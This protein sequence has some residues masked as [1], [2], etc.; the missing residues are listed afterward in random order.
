MH[1]PPSESGPPPIRVAVDMSN[2]RPAGENGGVKPFLFETLRWLGRQQRVPLQL[3]YLTCA[4]THAEV[5]DELARIDDEV[6]C[7]RDDG[8]PLPRGDERAPRERR[9]IP[10]PRDLLRQLGAHV[11]YSPFGPV[12][13]AAPGICTISTIVDVLH[14]DFPWSL[15]AQE[16]ASRESAFEEIVAVADR[17]QCISHHV[18]ARMQAHYDVPDERMFTVHIAVHGRF[19]VLAAASHASPEA[20]AEAPPVP[21][22]SAPF[23]FYPANTWK[24]KNHETLLLAYGIYRA[25][26]VAAGQ[27]PWPLVLTGHVD[28]RWEEL[29]TLAQTLGLLGHD[30]V[31][32]EGYVPAHQFGRLW[33]AAG[34]LV[35][36]SLHEGFGIPLLEAMQHDLPVL[37]SREGSLPEVG[38]DACLYVDARSPVALA[39]AM[40][41]LA[42]DPALR[43]RLVEA[44]RRRLDDFSL[45]RESGRL[46]DAIVELSQTTPPYRAQTSG[47]HLD[48]W[49]EPI[50]SLALPN[51]PMLGR[52]TLRFHAMPVHRRVRLRASDSVAFGSFD[53]PTFQ[54]G[55][56][57]SVDFYPKGAALWLDVTN[58]SNLDPEDGRVHGVH[59]HSA[60]LRLANGQEYLLLPAR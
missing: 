3:L 17:L 36:P 2:L 16:I 29:R 27:C 51:A 46:L 10:P 25:N 54:P 48:G 6:I 23:F 19:A 60:E 8:G 12:E 15:S 43:Q 31:R 5:R 21:A 52:L 26:A 45:E 37:A 33:E 18:V 30:A 38:G 13:F 41:R 20:P 55:Y 49:T 50:A 34:A 11:L 35:F 32:F 42:A 24:H 44:G 22:R 40:T 58:A 28:E 53:I 57:I 9:F 14:R 4:Q 59:L 47:I 39:D 1:M 7:V 56:E